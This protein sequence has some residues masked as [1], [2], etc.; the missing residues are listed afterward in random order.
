MDSCNVEEQEAAAEARMKEVR[1]VLYGDD[2]DVDGII[3]P[4]PS[5]G[6]QR[7]SLDDPIA[8]WSLVTARGAQIL[9]S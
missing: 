3:P 4:D 6:P 5:E 1:R 2:G 8:Q 9:T 7:L